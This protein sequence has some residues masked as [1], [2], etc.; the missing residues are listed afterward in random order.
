MK[1]SFTLIELIVV[2]AI[3]AVLAAIIAPN[4]FRAI[5]KAK[6]SRMVSDLTNI[7]KESLAFYADTGSSPVYV[8]GVT[9]TWIMSGQH[10]L[11]VD[12]GIF[13]WNGPYLEK[14][15]VAPSWV[16][17]L[18][19]GCT[20]L[21]HYYT[22]W[23]NGGWGPYYGEFDFNKDGVYEISNGYSINI[24]PITED[25]RKGINKALDSTDSSDDYTG[26][27]KVQGGCGGIITLYVG[28]I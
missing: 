4:A 15:A 3:I 19:L 17:S 12:V 22:Q 26:N 28:N 11:L 20:T 7:K 13:G 1:Q 8:N 16:G 24:F 2:I 21:G 10:P 25:I 9:Y 5:Q 18:A 23:A 27:L 6:V 14:P